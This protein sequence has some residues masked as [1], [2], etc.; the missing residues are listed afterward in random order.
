ML[1]RMFLLRL[2]IK[3]SEHITKRTNGFDLCM[4]SPPVTSQQDEEHGKEDGAQIPIDAGER[5]RR[6]RREE[7]DGTPPKPPH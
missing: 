2:T 4:A 3:E 5:Q 7:I 1:L 6:S